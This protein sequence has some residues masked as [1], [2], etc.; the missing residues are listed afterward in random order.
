PDCPPICY[1]TGE[2]FDLIVIAYEVWFLATA[3][4]NIAFLKNEADRALGHGRPVATLITCRNMWHNAQEEMKKLI[5]DA[6]GE[7]R[8]NVAFTDNAPTMATL[9]TTP[10][11]LLSGKRD[12]IPGL[13]PAGVSE[14]EIASADRFGRALLGPL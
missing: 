7:L 13:P 9:F 3:R 1:H 12:A 6:G 10:A 4:P 2:H 14:R 5:H 11:W 8:D